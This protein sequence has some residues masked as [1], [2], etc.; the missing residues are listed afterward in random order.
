M[1]ITI[2]QWIKYQLALEK[3]ILLCSF[4]IDIHIS[5]MSYD[6]D[7][8]INDQFCN[9]KRTPCVILFLFCYCYEHDV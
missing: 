8:M 6:V 5:K 9:E 2:Y 7:Y 4:E 1:S 3:F